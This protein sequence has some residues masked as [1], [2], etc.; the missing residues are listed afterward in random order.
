MDYTGQPGHGLFDEKIAN[1]DLIIFDRY[2]QRNILPAIYLDNIATR[3]RE[4]G[5][6]LVEAGPGFGM[7]EGLYR[8]P[9]GAI[10][11][12]EPSGIIAIAWTGC[13]LPSG[14]INV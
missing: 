5:A 11:P 8:S 14:S 7:P 2:Q 1:F 10:M 9:L 4:G 12:A 6:L 13:S 3:V